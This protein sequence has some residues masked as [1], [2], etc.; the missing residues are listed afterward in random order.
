MQLQGHTIAY[1]L[2]RTP[3]SFPVSL[4]FRFSIFFYFVFALYHYSP[5][6]LSNT[7][8]LYS[9]FCL[10]IFLPVFSRCSIRSS[11]P[12]PSTLSLSALLLFS[13]LDLP[14]SLS[15]LPYPFSMLSTVFLAFY[16]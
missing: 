11:F 1:L 15:P 5:S 13:Y 6:L 4:A 2:I 12:F 3:F 9:L 16:L 8:H 7:V 14:F 10:C